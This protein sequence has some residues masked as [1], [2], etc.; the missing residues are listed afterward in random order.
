M[1]C[2]DFERIWNERLDARGGASAEL[3]G[4]LAEHA[5]ACAD[6][7]RIA[8]GYQRLSQ[9]LRTLAPAVPPVDFLP[10]FLES[11]GFPPAPA[12]RILRFRRA[13]SSVAAAAALFLVVLI[14]GRSRPAAPARHDAVAVA[15]A[16]DPQSLTAALADA[17]SAT[18]D[19]ARET[20]GPA[21]R[22][23]REVFDSASLVDATDPLPFEVP[24]APADEVLQSVGDRVNAGVRPLSGAARHAFGF[25]LGGSPPAGD[26]ASPVSSGG[27]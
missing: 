12:P 23:G 22:F 13:I 17:G 27:A 21:A 19:L 20:S 1:K 18:L 9:A 26:D 25:L 6:C 3:D 11:Q 5:A 2:S 14:G 10:R 7:A 8:T 15:P 4:E 16:I 24:V